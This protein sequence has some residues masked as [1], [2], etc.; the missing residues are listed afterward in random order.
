M[1][2]LSQEILARI[3]KNG[4]NAYPEEGAGFL[5]G[6]DKRVLEIVELPMRVKTRRGTTVT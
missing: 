6:T 2:I 4:E 1:L 3:H 5:L